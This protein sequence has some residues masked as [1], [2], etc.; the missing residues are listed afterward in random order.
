MRVRAHHD[1][2]VHSVL[3]VLVGL[4]VGQRCGETSRIWHDL[5]PQLIH[6]VQAA[7]LVRE[8]ERKGE[9]ERERLPG[10]C[11]LAEGGWQDLKSDPSR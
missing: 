8:R 11:G 5:Q 9:R 4:E 2:G 3:V 6:N 1:A 10:K 7:Q